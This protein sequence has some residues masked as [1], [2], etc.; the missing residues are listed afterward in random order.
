M[1]RIG[2]IKLGALGDVLRTTALLGPLRQRYP[3]AQV[4]WITSNEAL[5]LLEGNPAIDRALAYRR[6]LRRELEGLQFDLLVSM[7]EEP[8]ACELATTLETHELI[9]A[10][11][12]P[13]GR[14]T[15]TSSSSAWFGMG[16][17][18]R[19]PDGSLE[20]ANAL[21]R[22]N[23]RTYFQIWLEI[24]GLDDLQSP[25]GGELILALSE[26]E[27]V[28]AKA[29]ARRLGIDADD[30][31]V[32]LNPGAGSRWPSKELSPEVAALLARRLRERLGAT[33]L[34]FGGRDERRR[35]HQI[36]RLARGVAINTG[37]HHPLREFAALIG[38]CHV[39][40]TTDSLALHIGAALKKPV[41]AVFGPTAAQE[42]ELYGRGVKLTPPQPCRCFYERHCRV[43][44][45][46]VNQVSLEQ[47]M[48]SVEV[49][50]RQTAP[51]ACDK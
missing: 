19:D 40:V 34:L 4:V 42:I 9:G 17:L 28:K 39:L 41:A 27:L 46:C 1:S 21:K 13:Q 33:V 49:M 6:S 26:R 45:S 24:L 32:G 18:N 51:G 43:A 22:Q 12:D 48:E 38:L 29:V 14:M 20:T 23:R 44:R 16:L 15:Y 5:A 35:N 37:T 47:L 36:E 10:Y 31:V 11:Q 7:D 2:I 3:N 25:D 30:R 50:L 8:H